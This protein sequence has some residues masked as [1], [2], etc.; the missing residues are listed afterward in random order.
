MAFNLVHLGFV[1][2]QRGVF[3]EAVNK[4]ERGLNMEEEDR[5]VQDGR[6]YQAIGNALIRLNRKNEVCKSF[7]FEIYNLGAD[8]VSYVS[9]LKDG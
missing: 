7:N 5:E 9:R 4:L 2:N 3:E 8:I 6:M 1:L